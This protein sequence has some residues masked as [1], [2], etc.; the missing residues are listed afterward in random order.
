MTDETIKNENKT[1]ADEYLDPETKKFKEG[2]PGGPGRP[3]GSRD[4]STDFEEAIKVVA[5]ETGK[6]KSE[7]RTAMLV[8]GISEA[9]KGNYNFWK[10]IL[11]RDYG[12]V[13]QD[14]NIEGSQTIILDESRDKA[15]KAINDALGRNTTDGDNI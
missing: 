13:S 3:K 1:R 9:R 2:N 14:I 10:E 11:E 7:I 5:E 15:K 12:K 6:T 4:W 8:K